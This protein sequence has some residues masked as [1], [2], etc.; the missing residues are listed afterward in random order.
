MTRP[1]PE[2]VFRAKVP[3]IV[4]RL[5]P[6]L[7]CSVLDACAIMGNLGHECMG[8][9][10]LQELSP[11]VA[12][13]AGGWGWAQWT[14]PRRRQFMAYAKGK[15]LAAD[16]D[17]ANYQ[18]LL[19]ELR[20]AYKGVMVRVKAK[21]TLNDKVVAF[22]AGYEGAGIKHYDSRERYASWAL[23]ATRKVTAVTRTFGIMDAAAVDDT[24]APVAGMD[25][26][27]HTA[28][29]D[30]GQVPDAAPGGSPPVPLPAEPVAPAM[31][32]FMIQAVQ[33]RLRALGYFMAG[34]AD[35][36]AGH[37]TATGIFRFQLANGL[38]ATGQLDQ[39]TLDKIGSAE[40]KARPVNLAVAST[41]A[42]DLREAK[43]PTALTAAKGKAEAVWKGIAGVMLTFGTFLSECFQDIADKVKAANE[44]LGGNGSI[45]LL[46]IIGVG[47]MWLAWTGWNRAHA[48]EAT[49]VDEVASGKV[50]P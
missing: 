11:T 43:D 49:K 41:T 45:F 4:N 34:P 22:E 3:A 44:A 19:F 6:D 17:E 39:A 50:S 1:N 36:D 2:T 33:D 25:P 37:D 27:E 48:V 31:P 14:G 12:G 47:L 5:M 32:G 38:P 23:D 24:D 35:G 7:S 29:V 13:S 21:K 26:A 15:S 42:A 28:Q 9:T 20:G 16:S 46:S 30:A 8:F 40:A 18:F 10:A